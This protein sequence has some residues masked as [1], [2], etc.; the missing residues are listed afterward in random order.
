MGYEQAP[1]LAKVEAVGSNRIACSSFTLDPR[2]AVSMGLPAS[3]RRCT[4]SSRLRHPGP[5]S[6][7]TAAVGVV[8]LSSCK[9]PIPMIKLQAETATL[10]DKIDVEVVTGDRRRLLGF[11]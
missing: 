5:V 2:F 8:A 11:D 3:W 1:I 6:C 4:P 10:S 7:L 9:S